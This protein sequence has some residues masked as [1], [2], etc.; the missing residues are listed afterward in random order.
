MKDL[1]TKLVKLVDDKINDLM[2]D[3]SLKKQ[4]I[5]EEF[6]EKEKELEVLKANMK[7]E[8][9]DLVNEK[10]EEYIKYLQVDGDGRKQKTIEK[11]KE[12]LKDVQR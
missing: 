10:C 5:I 6:E 11:F 1:K 7:I 12:G 4:E 8:I 9:E 3:L 2:F